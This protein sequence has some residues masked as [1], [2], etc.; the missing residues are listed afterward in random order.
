MQTVQQQADGVAVDVEA[1]FAEAD[2]LLA[3]AGENT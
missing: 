2:K 3:R 1:A